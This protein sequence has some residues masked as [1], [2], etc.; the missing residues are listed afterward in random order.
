MRKFGKK[1]SNSEEQSVLSGSRRRNWRAITAA[2]VI[3]V[4]YLIS[5]WLSFT[6]EN[7]RSVVLHIPPAGADYLHID[8]EVVQVDLLRSE[9]TTRISF[10]LAGALAQ[11]E[12]TPSTELRLVVNSVRGQQQFDFAKGERINPIEVTFPLDGSANIYPFDHHKG[13]IWLF[14]TLPKAK[15]IA[16]EDKPQSLTSNV[17]AELA[18][19]S[20]LPINKT[21][22]AHEVQA[23][24]ETQFS[25]SIPGL[26]FVTTRAVQSAQALKGLTGIEVHVMRSL[27]V[28]TISITAMVMMGALAIGVG[29]MALR[30]S[31]GGR[32]ITSYHIPMAVSLIFGLPALRNIQPGVP[33]IGT[34]GD[35][36]VFIWSEIAAAGSAIALVIHWLLR[37]R[38]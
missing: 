4:I 8:I 2:V 32:H 28:V 3:A 1:M 33:P 38:E 30:I 26:T 29:S 6:E 13:D 12:L 9:L 22:L 25:A 35:A 24:T 11:A 16:A 18:R 23:D 37:H 34:T 5:V 17:P 10:T 20:S 15:P 7:R 27:S 31:I 21:S 19:S 36:M 14:L